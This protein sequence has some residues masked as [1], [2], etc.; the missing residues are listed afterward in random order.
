LPNVKA[1]AVRPVV[2]VAAV[3]AVVAE[4]EAA[5]R[6]LRRPAVVE[7]LEHQPRVDVTPAAARLP[8]AVGGV[9]EAEDAQPRQTVGLVALTQRGP[10]VK[11]IVAFVAAVIL[12]RRPA[13]AMAAP[14]ARST[15]P[16]NDAIAPVA[17]RT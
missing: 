16:P 11:A 3:V 12:H 4:I 13:A 1:V 8:A 6:L 2:V 17:L 5:V 10:P 15:A 7:A 14:V 9:V